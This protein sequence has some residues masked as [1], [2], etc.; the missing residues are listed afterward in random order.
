MNWLVESHQNRIKRSQRKTTKY[1]KKN[2]YP[3]KIK[4]IKSRSGS[5]PHEKNQTP[6]FQ[7]FLSHPNLPILG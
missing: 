1:A 6:S 2:F 7:A 4:S 5:T 3:I